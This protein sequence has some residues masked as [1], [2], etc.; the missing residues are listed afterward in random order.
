MSAPVV[1]RLLR[2]YAGPIAQSVVIGAVVSVLSLAAPYVTMR[3]ID[4]AYAQRNID[5]VGALL[6]SGAVVA[7]AAAL[8]AAAN[9]HLAQCLD[10]AVG[11][12][13]QERLYRHLQTLDT[14]FYERHETGELMARFDD[15]RASATGLVAVVASLL[16]NGLQLIVFP[17]LLLHLHWRLALLALAILPFDAA[18]A[19]VSRWRYAHLGGAMAEAAAALSARVCESLAGIRVIQ[20]LGAEATFM[21]QLGARLLGVAELRYQ[22]SRLQHG[23]GLLGALV[24]V[25][26]GLAYSW[27]GWSEVL[28]GHLSLG[29]LL[30][31][32][33]YALCLYGPIQALMLL[34]PQIEVLLTHMRRFVEVYHTQPRVRDGAGARRLGR[35]LGRLEF[36]QVSYS[37]G[38]GAV[39]DQACLVI[40]PGTCVAVVGAS[41]AGKSTLARM[42]PR[43]LDPDAGA[44]YLDGHDL[45]ECQLHSLRSQIGFAIQGHGLFSGT[46]RDNL[47]LGQQRPECELDTA[48]RAAAISD[49][50]EALPRGYDTPLGEAGVALSEG[51]KQRL[52]LARVFLLD[53]PILVLDEP[54]ASLDAVSEAAVVRG[55]QEVRRG[56]TCL[57][58]AHRSAMVAQ[59]DRVVGLRHGRISELDAQAATR[60]AAACTPTPP[61]A[62]VGHRPMRRVGL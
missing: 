36:R 45:R 28:A 19:A 24:R 21:R 47:T 23:A 14:G 7:A 27:Y 20:S 30:A 49:L 54:T 43:F 42:V 22:M 48:V 61:A 26:G 18:L 29:A 32:S 35:T 37:Y 50:V 33:A 59:A 11:L 31:F 3:L 62:S 4:G 55:F 51:Q 40:E 60:V 1:F 16:T 15:L 12:D 13:L 44:V 6:A 5:L 17:V 41:G 53:R 57:V 34:L 56:R 46:V 9:G 8:A 2:P 38:R 10:V 52:A 25:A 58:V 39:L